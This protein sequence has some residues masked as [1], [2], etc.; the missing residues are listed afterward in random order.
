VP[1]K[2]IIGKVQVRWWPMNHAR[3]FNGF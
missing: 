3:I 2:Y 1:K